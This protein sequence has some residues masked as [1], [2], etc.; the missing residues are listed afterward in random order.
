MNVPDHILR[1]LVKF[2]ENRPK[3]H[4]RKA[5]FIESSKG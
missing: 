1:L 4:E 5:R 2:G 3:M